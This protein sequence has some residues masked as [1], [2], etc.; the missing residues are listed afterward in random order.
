[1]QRNS[2][3][4]PRAPSPVELLTEL[5]AEGVVRRDRTTGSLW[6]VY[7]FADRSA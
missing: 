1:M 3:P 7:H 5:E 2:F 4:N 6:S